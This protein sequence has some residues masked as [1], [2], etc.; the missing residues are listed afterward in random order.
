[1]FLHHHDALD[2][3]RYPVKRGRVQGLD[4]VHLI[5]DGGAPLRRQ[6]RQHLS[7]H[8]CHAAGAHQRQVFPRLE[9]PRATQGRR[10]GGRVVRLSEAAD[11]QV[12]WSGEREDLGE[13]AGT[14][15]R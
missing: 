7:H 13:V 9:Q 4:G 5:G 6:R 3:A 8:P 14:S 11:A 15:F 2:G 1:M 12:A 10:L